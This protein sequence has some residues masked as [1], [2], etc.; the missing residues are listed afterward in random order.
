M[1][2]RAPCR[3]SLAAVA[4]ASLLAFVPHAAA[5][6]PVPPPPER[7][8]RESPSVR[9]ERIRFEGNRALGE[10]ELRAVAAKYEGRLLKVEDLE[11]LR[12]EVTRRYVAAGFLNSGAVIP[13]QDIAAGLLV[14]R[15]VEGRLAAAEVTGEHAFQPGFLEERLLAGAGYPLNVNRLQEAMQLMLQEGAIERI[16]AELAPGERPG[17]AVLRTR[18]REAP[19]HRVE[20]AALNNRPANLGEPTGELRF[21][22]RNSTGWNESLAASWARTQGNDEY[23]LSASLPFTARD[24]E[25]FV[26]A[27]R[28]YGSVVEAPFD[29]IGLANVSETLEV[30][31]SHP[32]VRTLD[33]SLVARLSLTRSRTTTYIL[34]EPF[35]ILPGSVD[36]RTRISAVR[37]AVEGVL[38]GTDAVLAARLALGI[39]LDAMSSTIHADTRIP[40][41]QFVTGLGQVQVVAR[42]SGASDQV[43]ARADFQLASQRL[44]SSEQFPVGGMASV[45]GYR[46]NTL[47]RDEGVAASLEYR[48]QVARLPAPWIGDGSADGALQ[49]A[50]FADAGG[51]RDKG[52]RWDSLASIGGGLRWSAGGGLEAIVYKAFALR[53]EPAGDQTLQ[54]RG[55][56][57]RIGYAGSF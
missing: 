56:H 47:I 2:A 1:K 37:A 9:V 49:L 34:D 38:R 33:R 17:E 55:I 54:D 24:D 52:G 14:V 31:A 48:R 57:F 26:R 16:N 5:Q 51:G 3:W 11:E 20:I 32:V 15:I 8:L 21:V 36:G 44:A 53:N 25:L 35:P 23:A 50:A 6:A 40:D 7:A 28:N 13:D 30:G 19:R 45:R 43:V 42:L 12:L 29:R 41:S 10:E 18:V 46:E 39:G 4:A 22:A 27:G